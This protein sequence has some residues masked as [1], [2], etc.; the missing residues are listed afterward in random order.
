MNKMKAKINSDLNSDIDMVLP[1]DPLG[2]GTY[3]EGNKKPRG[4]S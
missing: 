3:T 4:F 2:Y 1:N